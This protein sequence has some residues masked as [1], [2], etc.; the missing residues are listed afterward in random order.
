MSEAATPAEPPAP[1]RTLPRAAWTGI[2]AGAAAIIFALT[3]FTVTRNQSLDSVAADCG[4]QLAGVRADESGLLVDLSAGTDAL[5][6]VLPKVLPDR[7]DQYAV[8]QLL[9]GESAG[10]YDIDG[11]TVRVGTMSGSDFVFFKRP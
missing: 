4:G 11:Q 10:E 5:L 8:T 1:K 9:D 3:V 7:A 2:I 6:C